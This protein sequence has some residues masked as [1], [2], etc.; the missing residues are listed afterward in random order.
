MKGDIMI[1]KISGIVVI[2]T[3]VI[4]VVISGIV[5]YDQI[6]NG[7]RRARETGKAAGEVISK[8]LA[9]VSE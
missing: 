1:A 3:S 5:A 4:G 9:P 2:V 6:K 7:D 8:N